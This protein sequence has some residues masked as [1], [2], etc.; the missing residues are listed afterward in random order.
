MTCIEEVDRGIDLGDVAQDSRSD[1]VFGVSL[2]VLEQCRTRV[3]ALIVVVPSLLV[4]AHSCVF[5]KLGDCKTVEV[6]G[7]LTL[8][9]SRHSVALVRPA[10]VSARLERYMD[11]A[12]SSDSYYRHQM[13]LTL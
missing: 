4:H 3:S 8:C 11:R 6:D 12:L 7:L 9:R 2:D 1:A 13:L 10:L 5:L